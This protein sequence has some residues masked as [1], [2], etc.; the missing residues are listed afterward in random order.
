M[1]W[2]NIWENKGYNIDYNNLNLDDLLKID[3]FNSHGGGVYNK[4]N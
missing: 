1:E 3:G 2:K 4:Y